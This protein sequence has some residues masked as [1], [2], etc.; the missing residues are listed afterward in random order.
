M[1]LET[2]TPTSPF[3][4]A[5]PADVPARRPPAWP[6]FAV[7]VVVGLI[8]LV[9][10]TLKAQQ[11]ASEPVGDCI[12]LRCRALPVLQVQLELLL[13]VWLLSGLHGFV[14]RLA[15]TLC[16]AAFLCVAV[17]QGL[18]GQASCGC[19]G[20]VQVNPWI[21]AALDATVLAAL[22]LTIRRRTGPPSRPSRSGPVRWALTLALALAV[23]AT[24]GV[25]MVRYRPGRFDADGQIVGD[26][27]HVLLLPQQWVGRQC[28]LLD[29]I[30]IG[31]S[32]RAGRWR[33]LL[34]RWDCPEC[35]EAIEKL[36]R[37]ERDRPAIA[38]PGARHTAVVQIPPYAPEGQDPVPGD[39]PFARGRLGDERRWFV[40]T[41]TVIEL[42]D[43]RVLSSQ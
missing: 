37:L 38:V 22:L 17:Y 21:T 23:T 20:K 29:H 24:A 28:P 3:L 14:S 18:T 11:L 2:P 7:R 26:P 32:L 9:A 6:G 27:D 12:G 43:G 42:S 5:S 36:L 30:D 19:F 10:A 35:H 16:F 39:A 40:A 34:Y 4:P 41:P 13:G 31:D 15:A 25:N 1:T 8:L 33:L